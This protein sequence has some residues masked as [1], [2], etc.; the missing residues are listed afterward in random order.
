[1]VYFIA[2]VRQIPSNFDALNK[3]IEKTLDISSNIII[4]GDMNEDLLNSR[5]HNLRDVLLLNSLQNNFIIDEPTRQL[6]LLDPI[7]LHKDISPLNQGIFKV[8]LV[9]SDHSAIFFHE[10]FE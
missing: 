6:A 2:H 9:K 3:N 10:P 4:L 5:L 1:M 8:P 7:I